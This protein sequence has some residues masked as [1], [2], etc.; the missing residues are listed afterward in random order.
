MYLENLWILEINIEGPLWAFWAG[1]SWA[2]IRHCQEQKQSQ[3]K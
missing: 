1:Q 2:A 3:W